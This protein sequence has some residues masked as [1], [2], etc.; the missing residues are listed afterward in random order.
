ML[1][2]ALV[3]ASLAA[4]AAARLSCKVPSLGGGRDDGPAISAAFERCGRN[5]KVTLD[6]YYLVDS[7]LLTTGLDNV[8]IE[9]SGFL[10][11]SPDIAKWSPQS[12]FLEY[13]N[14]TTF[15]F[16]SGQNIH[17]YGGGTIDGNGQ[18]WWDTF[19]NS[20]N[21]G[22]AGGSS[23][24]FARPIPLTVGN[25]SDVVIEDIWI[26]GSPFW[27]NFV[28][29]SQNVTY[30]NISINTVSYSSSPT[31]NSDGWDIYR[32]DHVTITDSWIN[33]DDDCVSFKPNSTNIRVSNL[34]C[35]GSHGV[36]VGSL[37]QY[38]GETD[39]VANV[40]VYNVSMNNAQNGARIKVFGGNPSPTSTVGGG[41]GFVK[42]ITWSDYTLENV[43]NPIIIDQC[44]STPLDVCAQFPSKVAIS[45]VHFL[46]VTGTS[47]GH[48]GDIVVSLKCSEQCNNITATGT[49]LAAPDGAAAYICQNITSVQELDF[50]CTSPT[51]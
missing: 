5:G 25:A 49:H 43:D 22:T 18:V 6:K 7:L 21:A 8:D 28:Y 3:L 29:Q 47:S 13:Q 41:D 31:A 12:Y 1:P 39:I 30:K 11:Y 27:N 36:S 33:N 16:L 48:N 44:Y 37:G 20:H 35:N 46:N 34:W 9:L 40:S 51:S 19:N 45:D 10:Q 26:I 38:A 32:S 2:I 15:W 50:D 24:T 17:M 23:R 4:T 42:N 14:A